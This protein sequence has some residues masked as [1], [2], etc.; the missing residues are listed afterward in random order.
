M[1]DPAY[2]GK[3][4]FVLHLSNKTRIGCAN[5]AMQGADTAVPSYG[6]SLPHPSA[7]GHYNATMTVKP[8]GGA[9]VTPTSASPKPSQF[10]GAAVKVAGGAGAML[11]AVAAF[12]L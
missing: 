5:F 4:S 11:A 9:P 6:A 10:T 3:L 12:V 1:G 2:F 8:T 7:T